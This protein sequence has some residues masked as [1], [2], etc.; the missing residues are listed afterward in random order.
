MREKL[1]TE[2]L[3]TVLPGT[4]TSDNWHY[5]SVASACVF[6]A[7]IP[8][9]AMHPFCEELPSGL[10]RMVSD[11]PAGSIASQ[12][13]A[14]I[15]HDFLPCVRRISDVILAHASVLEMPPKE[16]L[17]QTFPTANWDMMRLDEFSQHW[18][19]YVR[20][21]AALGPRARA[22]GRGGAPRRRIN[23]LGHVCNVHALPL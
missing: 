7:D 6:M 23:S 10:L 15:E 19:S 21:W 4:R 8:P 18:L 1:R 5:D 9:Q 17:Q 13:R 11:D 12:Y 2:T 20:Q 14:Y 22:L 16:Y 3:H